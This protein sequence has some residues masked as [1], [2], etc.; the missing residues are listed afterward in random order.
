M[1]LVKIMCSV[2]FSIG[3]AAGSA[4]AAPAEQAGA[5]EP[6]V[7]SCK[8]D[9]D[10]K[11][12]QLKL[13]L[14]AEGKIVKWDDKNWA[15]AKRNGIFFWLAE[16]EEEDMSSIEY[17]SSIIAANGYSIVKVGT[18]ADEVSVGISADRK[19][20]FFKYRDAGSGNGNSEYPLVCRVVNA[21][22]T[23]GGE[24]GAPLSCDNYTRR[25]ACL[26]AGCSWFRTS[27]GVYGCADAGSGNDDSLQAAE[28][29]SYKR[30]DCS[31]YNYRQSLCLQHSS[32]CYW[33]PMTVGLDGLCYS[34]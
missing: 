22:K 11:T 24:K 23:S 30:I 1:K 34:R 5:G 3:A 9:V 13:K 15:Q 33:A 32:S 18:T 27:E 21:K 29:A 6:Q 10:G 12:Q 4:A 31:R 17:D 7:V 16:N 20:G 26:D 14:D 28:K 2:L 8:A 25:S 19:K